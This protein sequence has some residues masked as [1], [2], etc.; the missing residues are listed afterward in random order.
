[1]RQHLLSAITLAFCLG[2]AGC[3]SAPLM[4]VVGKEE[5]RRP[6]VMEVIAAHRDSAGTAFL[7]VR[8]Q[9]AGRN[10]DLPAAT[11]GLTVPPGFAATLTD[12]EF[13]Y[14]GEPDPVASYTLP[15]DAVSRS[16]PDDFG[17][18]AEIPVRHVT[19]DALGAT[20]PGAVPLETLAS[21]VDETEPGP[22]LYVFQDA[23]PDRAAWL[24]Y[25]HDTPLFEGSRLVRLVPPPRAVHP[26]RGA[27]VLLPVTM[28]IDLALMAL[29]LLGLALAG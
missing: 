18:R 16:C 9:R 10:P 8:G 19:A 22:A 13:E 4:D 2:T 1:M 29:L 15:A 28:T 20:G 26:N 5:I 24:V 7:C 23:N 11:Y 6:F 27:A 25:R 17:E 12:T 3:V 14:L 21:F